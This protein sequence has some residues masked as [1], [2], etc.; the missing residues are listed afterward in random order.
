M[1]MAATQPAAVPA[2]A[3]R[4][5]LL[6]E[7]PIVPTLLR[8]SVPNLVVN[9]VLITVTTTVDA[10]F[11]GRLGADALAGLAL[12]F[13]LLMLMQQ[14]ANF[15]MGGAMA[16]AVARAIGAGRR[17][18][19]AALAVHGLIIAL[20]VAVLFSAVFLAAG[21]AIYRALGGS[22]AILVAA[23]DYS[24]VIFA[25]AFAYWLLSALTSVVRGTGQVGVLAWVYIAAEI[26]HIGLVPL[27]VFGWGPVPAL[28]IAGAGIATVFSFTASSLFLA[29]YLASG[30][31]PIRLTLRSVTL[32]GRLFRDILRTGAPLSLQPILNN[33][34]L[35][36]LTS[37]A[38]ALGVATLAGVGAAVRLEYLMYPLVFGLGA[39]VVA[40][41]GTNIGAGQTAR[42][43]RIAWI[44]A[45]LAVAATGIVGVLAILWPGLWISLFTTDANIAAPAA[46]YLCVAALGYAFIGTNTLTQAFQAM[47]QTFWPLVAVVSR[48]VFLAVGGWIVINAT[49]SGVTG[50]A[51]V[52]ALG[53]AVAGAI[54]A[55]AFQLRTR[56]PSGGSP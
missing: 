46:A 20:A 18:E 17:E 28:G 3:A 26:L 42:A 5:R 56:S 11:I 15:S 30:R 36:L 33:V 51:I 44:A 37:Y 27:L 21:P 6:L 53:L 52:T 38:G 32:S 35:A 54:V 14:T 9:V 12:V 43:L 49:E 7:G 55:I 47:G 34:S 4:T 16:S 31:A 19:A 24:N 22:G 23:L 2:A 8:L 39:T 10:H 48:A 25:G 40:M 50:L 13:P 29:A 41:V 45:G 1:S